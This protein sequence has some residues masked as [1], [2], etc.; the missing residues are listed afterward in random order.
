MKAILF[1][2]D[3][4][5]VDSVQ[6]WVD[7]CMNFVRSATGYDITL[8]EYWD[9]YR[10]GTAFRDIVLQIGFDGDVDALLEE[11]DTEYMKRL[12]ASVEW[13]GDAESICRDLTETYP[14]AIV[15]GSMQ[16][17]VDAIDKKLGIRSLFPTIVASDETGK[18]SKP[19]PHGLLLAA[20]KLGVDPNE[21]MYIGEQTIDMKAAKA[22][23]MTAVLVPQSY[24]PTDAPKY[25][26]IIFSRLE[27]LKLAK[28]K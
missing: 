9:D 7:V 1:D 6:I 5:L 8:D 28:I 4:T 22:A 25:A 18:H 17:Y 13:I 23:G 21:C 19:D 27:D 26:D 24:T 3:G 14:C 20:E 10:D 12:E 11:R 2:L 15:T 16:Q